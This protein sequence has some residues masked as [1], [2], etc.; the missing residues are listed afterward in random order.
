MRDGI[1]QT[2]NRTFKSPR[3]LEPASPAAPSHRRMGCLSLRDRCPF[4][5]SCQVSSLP[6]WTG[7]QEG[8]NSVHTTRKFLARKSARIFLLPRQEL[9]KA[10]TSTPNITRQIL[11]MQKGSDI[12]ATSRQSATRSAL[13]RFVGFPSASRF[14]RI[15]S[16][17]HNANRP[18]GPTGGSRWIDAQTSEHVL[19]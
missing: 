14:F 3:P 5:P 4:G 13:H 12:S 18:P 7:T 19:R 6:P 1:A 8:S 15:K 16:T 9:K 11:I 10:C 2:K 17:V